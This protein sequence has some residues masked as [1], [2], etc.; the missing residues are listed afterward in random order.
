MNNSDNHPALGST[1]DTGAQARA[2]IRNKLWNRPTSG[3]APGYVQANLVIL[4]QQY[5]YDF[6]LFCQRNPKPCPLLEVT[7]LGSY[8]VDPKWGKQIDLRTDLPRYRVYR[9]GEVKAELEQLIDV[10]QD[11]F[12]SFLIGC[13]FTFEQALLEAGIPIRHQECGCNVPMYRT[14][15][16]CR[17]AGIFQGP[18]VVS[19]R[20]IPA[21][22]VPLAVT[23]TARY[24][25]VHGAPLHSG[26]P[27]ELGITDLSKPDYGD[28][29]P[30]HPGEIPVFW[31]CGV[32]PQAAAEVARIPL[33]ITHSPGHMLITDRLNSELAER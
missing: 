21:H 27:L 4:P 13:S 28:P 26:D 25:G 5:A 8:T 29:V 22:L 24:P 7:D 23:V 14:H 16:L 12:V 9:D 17:P 33:M 10:W 18:T 11:D 31:A 15:I 6:L 3:L 1:F 32:T 20:P 2:A 30:V 19:M